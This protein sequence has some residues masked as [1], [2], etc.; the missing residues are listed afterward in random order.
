MNQ[1]EKAIVAMLLFQ[2]R[3]ANVRLRPALLRVVRDIQEG[4]HLDAP[5]IPLDTVTVKAIY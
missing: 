1:T 2:I 4:R 3:L 5:S